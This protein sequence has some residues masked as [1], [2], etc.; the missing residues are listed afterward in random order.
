[1][2]KGEDNDQLYE[3]PATLGEHPG[4]IRD[5][6]GKLLSQVRD[7]CSGV[8]TGELGM[9][10]STKDGTTHNVNPK[11][12]DLK[13]EGE[14]GFEVEHKGVLIGVVSVAGVLAGVATIALLRRNKHE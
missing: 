10:I 14:A 1:M 13:V 8:S 11:D 6:A 2:E 12:L 4:S 7:A 3:D 5:S 9:C